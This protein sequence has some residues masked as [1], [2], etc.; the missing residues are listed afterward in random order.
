MTFTIRPLRASDAHQINAI[1]RQPGVYPNT[2]GLPSERLERSERFAA[3]VTDWDHQFV[4]VSA[5]DDNLVLGAIGL[6]ID[7][8]PRL[9]HSGY[10]GISVHQD[11]QG[12]GIGKALMAAV[13]DLADNWLLLKRLE[14]GVLAGNDRAL[15]LYKQFGFEVEGIKRSAVIRNGTYADETLMGRI[16]IDKA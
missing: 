14:L 9:R 10:I 1:R 5:E 12:K 3:N 15:E 6:H 7:S 8:N 13:V 4:A 16:R 2:L 11:Y